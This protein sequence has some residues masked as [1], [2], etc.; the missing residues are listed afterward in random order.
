MNGDLIC[1]FYIY[2]FGGIVSRTIYHVIVSVDVIYTNADI[3][4]AH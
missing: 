4:V 2:L 3:I 1:L